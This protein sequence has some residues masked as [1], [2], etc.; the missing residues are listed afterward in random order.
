M[1]ACDPTGYFAEFQFSVGCYMRVQSNDGV[2]VL[3]DSV[4]YLL[5]LFVGNSNFCPRS[6]L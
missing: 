5:E 1:L 4:S 6:E 2:L 3:T